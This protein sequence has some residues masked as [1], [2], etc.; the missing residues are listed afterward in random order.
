[1]HCQ[2]DSERVPIA[3]VGIGCRFPGGASGPAAF[4]DLLCHG[5][6]AIT[7]VPPDRWDWRLFY[8]TDPEKPGKTYTKQGGFLKENIKNFDPL[9]FG[10]SPREATTLDPQ[11]RLLLEVTWEALEDAGLSVENLAG[12]EAGV[13]IGC[14]TLDMKMLHATPFNRDLYTSTSATGGSMTLLANRISYVYDFH[15][16][17]MAIDTACSSSLVATHYACQS[18]WNGE[19]PLAIAGGVNVMIRPE[20]FIVMSKG[21]FLSPTGRCKTFDEAADGYTRG[22]GAGVVVLKPLPEALRDGDPIY[23]VIRATGV[24]QDGHTPG[25]AFPNENS[26]QTLIA[27]V[28]QQAGISPANVGYIEAH[29]TGTKA[30]DPIEARA[31]NHVVSKGRNPSDKCLVGS[32]KSNIGHLEAAAG[33]AGLI[34]TALSLKYRMIPPNLHFNNPNPDIPF[35]EMSIRVPTSL[36]G[37]PTTSRVP[38]LAGVN[39]FGYGGTNVHVLLEEPP[40]RAQPETIEPEE[41]QL[42]LVPI[43]ARSPGALEDIAKQYGA[44]L[45]DEEQNVS[46]ADFCHSVI[47]R[48]THNHYRCTITADSRTSLLDSLQKL[49]QGEQDPRLSIGAT[50]SPM[51]RQLVFVYTGMG[52]QWWGM[53]RELM[54]KS[55][56]FRARMEECDAIFFKFSNWSVLEALAAPEE[57]STI[58]QTQVA[59]PANVFIQAGLTTLWESLGIRPDA[60]VGHSVGEIGAAYAAGVLSLQDAIQVVYHRSRL[61]QTCAGSGT[62]L[63]VGLPKGA[64]ENLIEPHRE[65][66]SI[67]AVNS[68]SAVTL[69]GAKTSLETIAAECQEREIFN[70]F[71]KVEVPYHSKL[72]D[73]LKDELLEVLFDLDPRTA[74]IPLYSTVTGTRMTGLELNANYWWNNVRQPVSFAKA[75]DTLGDEGFTTFLE[76][77]PHPVLQ[78]SIKETLKDKKIEAD[79][80]PS[81]YREKPEMERLL[82]S[83]GTL[84]TLGVSI[85]W[86]TVSPGKGN[87]I[88]LPSYPWQMEEYWHESWASR[89]DRLPGDGRN[90]IMLHHP[91][92]TVP[93]TWETE[94]NAQLFPYIDDHR[95]DEGRIFPGGAYVEAGLAIGRSRLPGQ[96][97]IL[98]DLQLHKFLLL[99]EKKNHVLK[100]Q[101]VPD[102][103]RYSVW[104]RVREDKAEWNLHAT[105]KILSAKA[106]PMSQKNLA[107]IQARSTAH[108]V[109]ESY[110]P[111]GTY[112]GPYFQVINEIWQGEGEILARLQGYPGLEHETGGYLLHP[113]ILDGALQ[114]L[115]A[116]VDR[117]NPQQFVPVSIDRLTFYESPPRPCW[118]FCQLL[119]HTEDTLAGNVFILDGGGNVLVEGKRGVAKALKDSGTR[120]QAIKS[121][122]YQ[123]DWQPIQKIPDA[124]QPLGDLSNWLVVGSPGKMVDGI[125]T[126]LQG[127][128]ID[129]VRLS[130][131]HA[132]KM[133][134]SADSRGKTVKQDEGGDLKGSNGQADSWEKV[135]SNKER[136][137]F[138]TILYCQ[139]ESFPV[140]EAEQLHAAGTQACTNLV[141]LLGTL[142]EVNSKEK[143]RIGILTRGCL[144]SDPEEAKW[145]LVTSPLQGLTRVIRNEYPHIECILIDLPSE[146]T[147][148][149]A[150][151]VVWALGS[152]EPEVRISQDNALYVNRLRSSNLA[153]DDEKPTPT[154]IPTD[155]PVELIIGNPGHMDSLYFQATER[156]PPGPGEIEIKVHAVALNFKD[157]MKVLGTIS[158]GITENTYFGESFGMECSGCVVAIGDGVE[159]FKVGDQV[160]ATTNRG[161]FRSYVTAPAGY[162][163]IKPG[164]LELSDA[165]ILTVFLTAQY[166]LREVAD[167]KKGERILI[168]NGSGGVGL[169]AIQIAQRVGAEIFTT[170]GNEEKREY[171]RSLGISHVMDSRT[172]KFADDIEEITAGKGVDVVLNATWGE[173]LLKSFELLAPFGRFVEIGK[174]GID[175]NA[176]LPMRAFNRNLTFAAIDLDRILR[177]RPELARSLFSNIRLAF[178]NNELHAI[179]VH[180]FPAGEVEQAF[181]FMSQ[182]KHIGKVVVR[183]DQQTVSAVPTCQQKP[184]VR[185]DGTYLIT[186][187][188]QGFGLEIARWLVSKGAKTLVLV[189]RKGAANDNAKRFI[190][191][192]EKK[193]VQVMVPP[194]DITNSDEVK[195]LFEKIKQ[196]LPPLR[197]VVHGAMVLH[198]GLLQG[199]DDATFDKVMRP[200]VLGT[201]LLHQA[202][203]DCLL[204]FFVMLSSISAVTGTPGQGNYAAANSFLDHFASYRQSM[205]LPGLSINWGALGEVGVVARDKNLGRLL[206]GAGVRGIPVQTALQALEMA[207]GKNA[208]QVGVFDIDWDKWKSMHPGVAESPIFHSLVE[209][210]SMSKSENDSDKRQH[211]IAKLSL[212]DASERQTFLNALL[213]KEFVKVLQLP[214]SKIDIEEDILKMGVD[215]LM[216]LEFRNTLQSEFGLEISAVNLMQG[217]SITGIGQM[218][219]EKFEPL[220]AD[221]AEEELPEATL[222]DLLAQEMANLSDAEKAELSR[223]E[224]E[225]G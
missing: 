96:P 185:Q 197:G 37:W 24:N 175:E 27:R 111:G 85:D 128:G 61:Q 178:T 44:F 182:S 19:C 202:T 64:A 42:F 3:I 223:S 82:T 206:E 192:M 25:I 126:Y 62:M 133:T 80:I 98:E 99:Q 91:R 134:D 219:M 199:L 179:P 136:A 127:E 12:S 112:Y 53:G 83:L 18:L 214:A 211:L 117:N 142:W 212:L 225:M 194:L 77:G 31:I 67:G 163:M 93:P 181:R 76:V 135:T 4:W 94:V 9:F 115:V 198:D 137:P 177:D 29:G 108:Y 173:S 95:I 17:S 203:R 145:G 43:S 140:P 165:A 213:V 118:A 205:G 207:L 73:P 65:Y 132:F 33:I 23:S 130:I 143:L 109:I 48:R 187:G 155:Q 11:Q 204:D 121:W 46:L 16:P 149:M 60:V 144:S 54:K 50:K 224:K 68:H 160:I 47:F 84:F 201:L 36:E 26:Q 123:F 193:G 152:G 217:I 2:A 146:A 172:L 55:P 52:P 105:G 215:S 56:L 141:R 124:R 196:E 114:T 110:E 38:A 15:G 106:P 92:T 90:H 21:Q 153:T 49:S 41:G 7:E 79:V 66:V 170:A 188:T 57:S 167:L 186:G 184:L 180:E 161:C 164:S 191:D 125:T 102:T 138:N 195:R 216:A 208:V 158:A 28:Y 87:Y 71:L 40:P 183:M 20:Y 58:G 159:D 151:N 116:M 78:H 45:K 131:E 221:L 168:H 74:Q 81:L 147:N 86:T 35:D 169:A 148:E 113:T 154:P 10:I 139:E 39:S 210:Q 104:S 72:M 162:S 190:D 51:D 1:M 200:K 69:S 156:V 22:E 101:F 174:K 222:D 75:I 103:S 176:G 209:R 5:V 97:V 150:K 89:D 107:E 32:V 8:D 70:R 119:E 120:R 166:A 157:I 14:F 63:A 13:F 6:D 88:S 30:G 189:S 218:L 171:L 34:K 220:I 59:Q 122:F 100:L 129:C